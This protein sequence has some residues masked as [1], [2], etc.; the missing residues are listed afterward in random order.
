MPPRFALRFLRWFCREDCIEEIEGDLT[1][2]FEKAHEVNP[3][4]ARWKFAWSVIRYFRPEFMKS[5]KNYQPNAF[6][7]YRSYF[8]IGWRNLSRN[9]GYSFIN[10]GGLAMGMAVAMLI[11]LWMYDELTFNT[12]FQ[13][14]GRIGQIW[15][16]DTDP[17]TSIIDG[18]IVVQYPVATALRNNYQHYFKHVLVAWWITE[19]TLS[20]DDN[21]FIRKGEFIDE[22]VISM[23]SLKMLKGTSGS[24]NDPHSIIL[25]RSTAEAIFGADDPMNKTLK[26]DNRIDVQ[27][28][29]VYEDIPRNNNFSDVG[30]FSPW[31]LWASSNTWIKAAEHNWKN[32]SFNIYVQLQP[33]TTVEEANAAIY[34]FY[35]NNLPDDLKKEAEK[36]KSF[37]QIIPMN[38]WHLYTEFENGK[39]SGGRITFVWL[40]GIVGAFVLLLACINFINLSTA[41]SERRAKETG[42]RKAIGSVRTQLIGQ[43]LSES[44]LTVLTAFA[45]SMMLTSLSLPWFN[46]LADK[47]ISIPFDSAVFWIVIIVFLLFTSLMAGLYPAFYLSSFQP[48]KVLKGTIG[49][50]RFA[51]L[52]RKV[53]V[54]VQFS[55][56]VA[57]VIGTVVVYRQIQHARNRPIGYDRE[58]LISIRMM[59]P[60]FRGKYD[61]VR[62]ELLNTGF[63]EEMAFSDNP[64]TMAWNTYGGYTWKGKDPDID[65]HFTLCYVSDTYGRTVRWKITEGRDFDYRLA[66]DSSVIVINESAVKY[67]NLRNPVGEDLV[68]V[69]GARLKII[70]VVRDLIMQSPYEPVKPT[71]FT[72]NRYAASTLIIRMKADVETSE[73]MAEMENTFRR[74]VPTAAFDYRFVNEEYAKKFS[75]EERIGK[76]SGAFAALAIFIS[77]LGLFGLASFVA[78]QRTKEIGIRKIFGASVIRLWQMLAKDFIILVI[79]SC[80]IAIP[81]AWYFLNGWLLKYQYR[82]EIPWW[83]FV[84]TV[85]GAIIITLLTVS[86]QAI[87]AAMVNPVKSLRS[88]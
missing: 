19:Y 21:N 9:R 12:Y 11:G 49:L 15:A 58:S 69:S 77:S 1:E 81:V 86:F 66:S 82:T 34:D 32:R 60:A 5:V 20:L 23:L 40:F 50:G 55:V 10:I 41:R 75:Q 47:R 52:P 64:L 51:S 3:R 22:G 76:L 80:F 79:V 88:E 84:V 29:G 30:F 39:P 71:I 63:V 27:V 42:V 61:V 73:A 85:I 2:V 53:L 33:H 78:E 67:M 28:T 57:L 4:K 48:A 7:M 46:Q 13:N 31:E 54:V 35:H 56:S 45:F 72:W 36:H 26:I 37:A 38:K 18:S 44:C 83:I 59:D 65:S 70:G 68:D 24:L 62:D 6:S 74:I 43:F 14:Y 8:K 25:S 16:G 87:S 17:E